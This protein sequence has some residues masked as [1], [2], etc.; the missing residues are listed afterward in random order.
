MTLGNAA[1]A[2]VRLIIWCKACRHQGLKPDPA[3]QAPD[4]RCGNASARV[5]GAAGLLENAA[6]RKSIWS[7]AE[8]S[9]VVARLSRLMR[10]SP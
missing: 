9:A 4:M 6:A 8:P 7:S 10:T 3:E 5:A 2:R 1:L